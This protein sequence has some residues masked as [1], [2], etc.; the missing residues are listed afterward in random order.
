MLE[1]DKD[2]REFFGG[3]SGGSAYK[4]GLF[5]HKKTKRWTC[6]SPSKPIQLTESEAIQK[7]EEIRNDLVKGAEIISSFGPLNSE[8]DYEKLYQQLKDIPGINTV[9]KMK[10]YQMLFQHYLH[11]FTDKIIR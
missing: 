11:L 2:I 5:F 6:G 4:F 9:W 8:S 3:I 7:A 1:M 10:Y